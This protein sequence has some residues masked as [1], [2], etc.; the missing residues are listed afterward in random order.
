LSTFFTPVK[1]RL[2]HSPVL[3]HVAAVHC[4]RD[5]SVFDRILAERFWSRGFWAGRLR[6]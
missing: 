4:A 6:L 1:G 2:R 5:Q 3:R